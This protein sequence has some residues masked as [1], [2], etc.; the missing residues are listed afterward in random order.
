MIEREDHAL[1]SRTLQLYGKDQVQI[2]YPVLTMAYSECWIGAY[3]N[4]NSLW[5]WH[6]HVI[7]F[8]HQ[9]PVDSLIFA[10]L[11]ISW[12]KQWLLHLNPFMA[13]ICK[14][15]LIQKVTH[16]SSM[17]SGVG[18]SCI[19][20]LLGCARNPKWHFL[21]TG[22]YG[23]FQHMI[24]CSHVVI[25]DWCSIVGLCKGKCWMEPTPRSYHPST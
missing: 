2:R 22:N 19:Y 10:G 5:M 14:I 7:D 21:G 12:K 9:Y 23:L 17:H 6:F 25:R 18:A 8:V 24:E 15:D 13:L 1:N 20:P 3:L 16:H 4:D 11:K